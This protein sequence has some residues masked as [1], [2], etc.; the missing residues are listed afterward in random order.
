VGAFAVLEA[1]KKVRDWLSRYGK[2]H[3]VGYFFENRSEH[4]GEVEGV[5]RYIENNPTL[6]EQFRYA[7]W[8]WVPKTSAPAQAADMLAYEVWKECVNGLL[9]APRKYP[10][11]RSLK[12]LTHMVPN[13]TYCDERTWAAE[14]RRKADAAS[15]GTPWP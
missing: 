5:M 12:A 8:A 9:A 13:F 7:T 1:L 3:D 10:M 2:N 6:R 15:S 4:R 14:R 11:R